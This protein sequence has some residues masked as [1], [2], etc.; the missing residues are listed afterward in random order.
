MARS[1]VLVANGRTPAKNRARKLKMPPFGGN[2]TIYVSRC[3][4]NKSEDLPHVAGNG[5]SHFP[6]QQHYCRNATQG[7]QVGENP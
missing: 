2:P 1:P 4:V 7:Q 5:R 6:H 3:D